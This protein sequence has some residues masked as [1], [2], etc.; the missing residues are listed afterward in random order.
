M[1]AS[2]SRPAKRCS[3]M[4]SG[5]EAV[6]RPAPEEVSTSLNNGEPRD[7]VEAAGEQDG[8]VLE[9]LTKSYV[10][11]G[12]RT[13][14]VQDFNLSAAKGQFVAILGPSGC[15]KS[16]VLGSW[17]ISSSRHRERC[18]FTAYRPYVLRRNH[19]IGVAFQDAALLPWR[20]VE[21][22]VGLPLEI[23]RRKGRG[24][25]FPSCRAGRP[26]RLRRRAAVASV[27]RHE[28]AGARPGPCHPAR[29]AAAGRAV[30]RAGRPDPATAQFR[31]AKDLGR[32][33]DD[34][35]ARHHSIPEAVLLADTGRR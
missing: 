1:V 11:D 29:S 6:A 16:T 12:R 10:A 8:F 9:A 19:A 22:N 13:E 21:A 4:T 18:L 32:G 33:G 31:A 7:L 14:A 35:G 15:G 3:E 28:T 5:V 2:A 23:A 34:G 26:Q 30:R 25:D 27:G 17:P 20:N 24:A